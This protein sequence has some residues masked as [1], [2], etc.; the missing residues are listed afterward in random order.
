MSYQEE[1]WGFHFGVVGS[2]SRTKNKTSD[3]FQ[4]LIY[5]DRSFEAE[6]WDCQ[7]RYN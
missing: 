4:M 1:A 7:N 2:R 3:I 5:I 6:A